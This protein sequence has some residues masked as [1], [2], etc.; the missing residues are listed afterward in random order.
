MGQKRLR[1]GSRDLGGEFLKGINLHAPESRDFCPEIINFL[2]RT[3]IEW[4]RIHPLPTRRLRAR[5]PTGVSHLEA[6]EKYAEAGFNLIIPIDVGVK[7]NVGVITQGNLRAFVDDSYSYSYKAV[8]Q[9]E[10]KIAKFKR[11]VIYGIENEIDTKE[12]ILQ[13]A[14]TVG[15]RAG[16][17]TWLELSVDKELKFKRLNNIVSGIREASPNSLIMVNFEADDPVEDWNT[18]TSI[19]LAAQTVFSKLGFLEKDARERMNNY[20][21][22]VSEAVVRLRTF[23]IVG[24]DNY[25]NY[26]RKIP[27]RG[28]NI[29]PK[30]D[31]IARLTKKPVINVEFGYTREGRGIRRFSLFRDIPI[32]SKSPTVFSPEELQKRFFANALTSIENSSSQGTFPW[33]LYLELI[34]YYKPVEESGFSLMRIGS[35]RILEPVPALDY[36]LNWLA[37][38][39]DRKLGDFLPKERIA[40]RQEDLSPTNEALDPKKSSASSSK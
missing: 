3:P 19:M 9:I 18:Q 14:P 6:I 20:R 28:Q 16:P 34:H 29:G 13:S 7:E 12:W 27:P 23:D 8:K 37:E 2:R 39:D 11:T 1:V 40:N 26:F 30:T 15:W 24:L 35:N 22:D 36:Y 38:M 17:L 31:Y 5:G 10:T 25:P 32:D 4:V 21:L 33:V